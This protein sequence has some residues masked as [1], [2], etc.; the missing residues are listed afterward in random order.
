MSLTTTKLTSWRARSVPA[1]A[2]RTVGKKKARPVVAIVSGAWLAL[3]VALVALRPFLGLPSPNESDY[4]AVAARPFEVPG[5]LLGTDLIGR[6]ILARVITGAEVSLTVGIGA[7]LVGVLIGATLGVLSGFFG[8]WVDRSIGS[9]VDVMLAFPP[10]IATIALTVFLGASLT[11][12]VLAIGVV[13]SPQLARV[14]RSATLTYAHREF[15][16]AARGT[17]ATA[18]RILRREILP[19]TVAPVLAYSTVMVAVGI[20]AEAG[21][22]FLGL[23]VPPPRSSW[24]SMMGE[25]RS[26]LT[27]S[28][29]I[30]LIPALVMF[31]TLLAL[32]FLSE[33][34][35]RRF[36]IREAVL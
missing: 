18:P 1:T 15:V 33:Y 34:F 22:S 25:D 30:I 11:T 16:V 14:A 19:N 23:G 29:H 9:V 4:S 35:G 20:T 3:L 6:D 7:V 32:N 8:G 10:L 27:S 12:L 17:G 24:G 26:A 13:F 5:H 2:Q 36:D 31:L 21:I 28:P